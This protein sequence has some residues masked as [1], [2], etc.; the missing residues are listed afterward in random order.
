MDFRSPVNADNMCPSILINFLVT[1]LLH[2]LIFLGFYIF[3]SS[4]QIRAQKAF[5]FITL[6]QRILF[7]NHTSITEP[8]SS[9]NII[10]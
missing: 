1:F 6:F 2:L 4:F 7:Q 3:D 9:W 10:K 8:V 5:D